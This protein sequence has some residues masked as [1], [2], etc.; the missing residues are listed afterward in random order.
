MRDYAE[1]NGYLKI[2]TM[3][4]WEKMSM[5][6]GLVALQFLEGREVQ[7]REWAVPRYYP[8]WW[9]VMKAFD[10]MTFYFL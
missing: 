7:S 5:G 3:R 2:F 1:Q 8:L 4:L 10:V 9:M 6:G